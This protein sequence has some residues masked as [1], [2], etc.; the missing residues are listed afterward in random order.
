M[1]NNKQYYLLKLFII[2]VY[3]RAIT[4]NIIKDIIQVTKNN[5]LYKGWNK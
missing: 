5:R 3:A 2:I 1:K 4:Y